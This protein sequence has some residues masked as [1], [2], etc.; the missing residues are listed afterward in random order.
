MKI[1]LDM[2]KNKN[3]GHLLFLMGR[4]CEAGKNDEEAVKWYRKAIEHNAPEQIEAYQQLA[5]L[6]RDQLN[7][8][9]RCR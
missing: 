7:Q 4:C 8:A 2:E 6:L 3:D 1:L 5:T 9:R